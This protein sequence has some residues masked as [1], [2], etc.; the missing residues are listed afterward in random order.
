MYSAITESSLDKHRKCKNE[1]VTPEYMILYLHL[2]IKLNT[3]P[4]TKTKLTSYWVM[5]KLYYYSFKICSSFW[6]DQMK[7]LIGHSQQ[8]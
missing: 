4:S 1:S 8:K 5:Y 3:I 7:E 6:L 2:Q